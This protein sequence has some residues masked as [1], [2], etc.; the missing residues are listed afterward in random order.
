MFFFFFEELF[1]Q[2][3]VR[4][5]FEKIC[6]KK[7]LLD[8]Y[9]NMS[10]YI[11]GKINK[12]EMLSLLEKAGSRFSVLYSSSFPKK[13]NVFPFWQKHFGQMSVFDYD[14]LSMLEAHAIVYWIYK[15]LPNYNDRIQFTIE[16]FRNI[17][18]FYSIKNSI[19]FSDDVF[20]N[21]E[22]VE[23]YFIKSISEFDSFISYHSVKDNQQ[24]FY[25]G[26]SD[27]N[28]LLAPSIMRNNKWLSNESKMYNDIIINCPGHFQS[29][30]L[31]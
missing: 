5:A 26:H 12:P 29:A 1:Y 28:Y 22:K 14:E 18:E 20:Y 3:K 17:K 13:E 10:V 16:I 8:G 21:K 30:I 11:Q 9:I 31:I 2:T 7:M 6:T 23:L 27:T 19:E 4:E 24:L 25:R 15:I